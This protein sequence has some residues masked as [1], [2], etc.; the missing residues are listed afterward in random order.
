M[1]T[2]ADDATYQLALYTYERDLVNP[3][4]QAALRSLV[5]IDPLAYPLPAALVPPPA[6]VPVPSGPTPLYF[7]ASSAWNQKCTGYAVDPGSGAMIA[8][9]AA[10][11]GTKALS[12]AGIDSYPLYSFPV[13]VAP[14][15]SPH[16]K[17]LSRVGWFDAAKFAAV[18]M[19]AGARTSS[20]TDKHL[21]VL[22]PATGLSYEFW[23]MTPN[24]DGSWTA[25]MAVTFDTRGAGYQTTLGANSARAYGGSALGGLIDQRE[26]KQ[27][28]IPHALAWA[29]Q[30]TRVSW[31]AHG[32]VSGGAEGIASHTG[33]T[34]DT[35]RDTAANIPLGARIRLKATVDVVT[36]AGTNAAA[37]ILGTALQQYGAYLVDTAGA[38]T[39]YARNGTVDGSGL[40]GSLLT[41]AAASPFTPND[42][43]VCRLPALV[44][45]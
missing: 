6:P 8:N 35:S 7:S 23:N 2:L 13:Y 44:R 19:P 20:D 42:F 24:A 9:L 28:V 3:R 43:E 22:D 5:Q 25:S 32:P 10:A 1:S 17:V 29:Y 27:G 21:L 26:L 4:P 38:W 36:R 11:T 14:A 16:V 40:W 37:R 39:L 30:K 34:A 33:T 41:N 18:P 15:T 45:L 31:Y 12:I